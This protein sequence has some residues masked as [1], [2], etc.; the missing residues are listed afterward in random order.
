MYMP[1]HKEVTKVTSTTVVI[2]LYR[3]VQCLQY[4]NRQLCPKSDNYVILQLSA[5]LS[6][7]NAVFFCCEK[8]K[9]QIHPTTLFVSQ[10]SLLFWGSGLDQLV[11]PASHSV[12][13]STQR[14]RRRRM[15]RVFE[16][17]LCIMQNQS[18]VSELN[19]HYVG[20]QLFIESG[21]IKM[22]ASRTSGTQTAHTFRRTP[23]RRQKKKQFNR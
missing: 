22:H 18:F 21:Q 14:K 13:S 10:L 7:K 4:I 20:L 23:M 16:M 9:Q 1:M 17:G 3:N 2:Q 15:L 12:F 5:T 11:E 6:C 19:T 8:K